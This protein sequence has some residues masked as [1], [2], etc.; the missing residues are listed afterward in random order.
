MG[1]GITTAV[2][3]FVA[4]TPEFDHHLLCAQRP[5]HD[6]GEH[7]GFTAVHTADGT[8]PRALWQVLRE[9]R[10]RSAPDVVHLHSSWAGLLGRVVLARWSDRIVYSPHCYW[11]ERTD[12]P[13]GLLRA[14]RRL[15]RRLA[16]RTVVTVAVSPHEAQLASALGSRSAFVP[17]VAVLPP[18]ESDLR[19]G[20]PAGAVSD[21]V[22]DAGVPVLVT[23]GR[24]EAQ[25]DPR[26]FAAT[27]DALA[28]AGTPVRAVWVGGG[29]PALEQV[30]RSSGVHVTGW[31]DRATVLEHV[32]AADVYVHTAAWEGNPLTVLEATALGLRTAVRSIPAMVSLGHPG[33]NDTPAQLAGSVRAATAGALTGTDPFEAEAA[34]L[35]G[36]GLDTLGGVYRWVLDRAAPEAV[37][38]GSWWDDVSSVAL[39]ELEPELE[40]QPGSE[41]RPG[42]APV[43]EAPA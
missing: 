14:V 4:S 22:P 16:R 2:N 37:S 24:V 42:S 35:L 31:V 8:G 40:R 39:P 25:K 38:T 13:A 6:T 11:F 7:G 33:G 15:E 27:V 9:A 17:N 3:Q 19:V 41:L 30:L 43:A 10:G 20:L 18:A 28:A 29:D 5:R 36:A 21:V 34:G 23:V 26:F 12:K 32:T 1:G